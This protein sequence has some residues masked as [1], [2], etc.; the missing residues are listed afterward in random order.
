[1]KKESL[2]DAWNGQYDHFKTKWRNTQTMHQKADYVR[3]IVKEFPNGIPLKTVVDP[4]N[5][6]KL[7]EKLFGKSNGRNY[8]L[9]SLFMAHFRGALNLKGQLLELDK[10]HLLQD[11]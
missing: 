7:S 2:V 1:M 9:Y 8:V 11:S 6:N 3:A 4:S 5:R 10:P